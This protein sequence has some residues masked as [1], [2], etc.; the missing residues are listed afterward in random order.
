MKTR[1]YITLI[2]R[3]WHLLPYGQLLELV[4]MTPERLASTLHEDDFLLGETGPLKPKC[5]PLR[6][7]RPRRGLRRR[8]A[9]IASKWSGIG[10]EIAS[11]RSDV[12]ICRQLSQPDPVLLST[13]A[14]QNEPFPAS[15]SILLAVYGDP[16]SDPK[17]I[18]I[19]T[20][21]RR[22]FSAVGVN[23]GLVARGLRN[24]RPANGVAQ[25]APTHERRLADLRVLVERASDMAWGCIST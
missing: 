12:S 1:G 21:F 14:R 25:F 5:E 23:G 9:K 15:V 22:D 4:E 24:R 16:L 8:A 13:W 17:S 7:P 11:G 20:D 10:E 18:P 2:R 6:V 19:R 3:N